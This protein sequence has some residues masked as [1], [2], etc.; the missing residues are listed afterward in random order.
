MKKLLAVATI[1]ICISVL[2]TNCSNDPII[3]L[4]DFPCEVIDTT[5]VNNDIIGCCYS[6]IIKVDTSYY[7]ALM[8]SGGKITTIYRKLNL[9]K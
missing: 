7:S 3:V 6:V 2:F 8:N 5:K 4:A 9:N 1:I